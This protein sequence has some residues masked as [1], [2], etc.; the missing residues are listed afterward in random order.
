[1]IDEKYA[2]HAIEAKWQ[3][4]WEDNKTFKREADPSKPKSYVLEMFPYP[5]GIWG[6]CVIILLAT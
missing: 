4:Y 6:M 2:P 5:S 3:K 1:M